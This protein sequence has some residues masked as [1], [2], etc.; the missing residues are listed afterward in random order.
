MKLLPATSFFF[1]LIV[2]IITGCERELKQTTKKSKIVSYYENKSYNSV[3]VKE[4]DSAIVYAQKM[5]YHARKEKSNTSIRDAYYRLYLA[6]NR[7]NRKDSAKQYVDKYCDISIK[8]ADTLQIA[9]ALY[10]RGL[11]YRDVDSVDLAYQNL[12]EAKKLYA[13][14][15]DSIYAGKASLEIANIQKRIGNFYIAQLVAQDGIKYLENLNDGKTLSGLY[16]V[17]AVISKENNEYEEA[18]KKNDS[19][20]KIGQDTTYTIRARATNIIVYK[21]TRANIFTL[22]QEPD[23]AIAIYKSLLKEVK[24]SKAI[25]RIESNL[26]RA[27]YIKL[28]FNAISDSLLEKALDSAKKTDNLSLQISVNKKL[29]ELYSE[30]DISVFINYI[31]EAINKAKELGNL[32]SI[33]EMMEF[34]LE[35]LPQI[36]IKEDFK[37]EF[38]KVKRKLENKRKFF[39]S[40][41][42]SNK[43]DFD[44][45]ESK[46]IRA[47]REA[48]EERQR[49]TD[50]QNSILILALVLILVLVAI[51]FIYQKIKRQHKIEKVDTVHQTEARISS[52]VHDELANDIHNLMAQL[53]TSDPE[54]EFVLDKLDTIYNNARDISKQNRSVE[55]GE[56]FAEEVTNLFRSYQSDEVNVLLKRY[57]IAIWTQVS[58]HIK[59]TIYRVLQELLTNM[60]KHS[61]AGL[62]VVSIE[63]KNK[64]LFI[65]YID[66]GKGFSKKISKNGLQNAENRI[67]AIQ[68]TL[69]FDTQLEKGCKFSINVPI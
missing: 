57:D 45:S 60:K 53:E 31:D 30:K 9:K 63:K 1:I 69:T 4:Y 21:E 66:N 40:L 28:G 16:H 36:Q 48:M 38:F 41:Y 43:F 68:G 22:Q 42:I 58:S 65:Q 26:A 12:A 62:V 54:K 17:L 11:F 27:M 5:L 33:Y 35:K 61:N 25:P 34:K 55:T 64:E 18:L 44:D 23:K 2:Y 19:S 32:S 46:R 10:Y 56:G 51:F 8:N 6:F 3:D 14:K 50:N 47:E 52:K 37:N 15:K 39:N 59:V 13:K 29:A 67:H 49:A 7:S 20:L 24:N